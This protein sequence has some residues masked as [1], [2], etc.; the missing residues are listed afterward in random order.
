MVFRVGEAGEVAV[1]V[2]AELAGLALRAQA[3]LQAAKGVEH[4]ALGFGDA[5]VRVFDHLLGDVAHQVRGVVDFVAEVVAD[6]GQAVGTYINLSSSDSFDCWVAKSSNPTRL[7]LIIPCAI[8]NQPRHSK[9]NAL[10]VSLKRG[11]L[12]KQIR[13]LKKI[14]PIFLLANTAKQQ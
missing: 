7:W 11:Y 12:S 9:L 13:K 2:V 6:G 10:S 5:A 14:K 4:G 1:G 8:I 3:F